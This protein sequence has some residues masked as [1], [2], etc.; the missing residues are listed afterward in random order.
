[1]VYVDSHVTDKIVST[2]QNNKQPMK[3]RR[4]IVPFIMGLM[5][6]VLF[7]LQGTSSD[8]LV[9][10]QD[11]PI[12]WI[13]LTTVYVLLLLL[14]SATR[15]GIFSVFP[16]FPVTLAY[17]LLPDI[18]TLMMFLVGNGIIALYQIWWH[19]PFSKNISHQNTRLMPLYH[20]A[21]GI[22]QIISSGYAILIGRFLSQQAMLYTPTDAETLQVSGVI[23]F[24]MWGIMV[25][26]YQ[27][28]KVLLLGDLKRWW[29]YSQRYS[30]RDTLLG[31]SALVTVT[32]YFAIGWWGFLV[33]TGLVMGQAIRITQTRF[34]RQALLQR[35]SEIS[36]MTNLARSGKDGLELN[37]VM[38]SI[39]TEIAKALPMDA[40]FIALDDE[41]N[42]DFNYAYSVIQHRELEHWQAPNGIHHLVQITMQQRAYT[43]CHE[44]HD[45]IHALRTADDHDYQS[46]LIM[47]LQVGI[48]L[49]GAIGVMHRQPHQYDSRYVVKLQNMASQVSLML[50]NASLYQKSKRMTQQLA[51]INSVLQSNLLHL[52]KPKALERACQVA[53]DIAGSQRAI[54]FLAQA[55]HD[56]T[57][58]DN[59]TFVATATFSANGEPL[60]E[61]DTLTMTIQANRHADGNYIVNDITTTND[62]LTHALVERIGFQAMVET[63]LHSGHRTLG[64][65]AV[66]HTQA[67]YYSR[68]TI[69]L[70]SMVGNQI[71]TLLE[72]NHMLET[73]E[74]YATEQ[75]QLANL[76]RS[77]NISL[78]LETMLV[79]T[80]L[81]LTT[82][83]Q[84]DHV[85]IGLWD[86][87]ALNIYMVDNEKPYIA[88][89]KPENMLKQESM[90]IVN[91]P[92]LRALGSRQAYEMQVLHRD[93][94]DLARPIKQWLFRQGMAQVMVI[95][96]SINQEAVG[97][98]LALHKQPYTYNDSDLRL[99]EMAVNQVTV[100][101]HNGQLH[102]Q[103]QHALRQG[104]ERLAVIEG[105]TQKISEALN[106]TQ[107][108]QHVLDAAMQSTQADLAYIAIKNDDN[109]YHTLILEKDHNQLYSSQKT[110]WLDDTFIARLM[111]K[112]EVVIVPDVDKML[113]YQAI[114][115][116]V[117]ASILAVPITA[118]EHAIGAL[119]IE[120]RQSRFFSDEHVS[121]VQGI[122]GHASVSLE[123]AH[124][125]AQRQ[126]QINT[127]SALRQL[128]LEA[129]LV[130][131][132][133]TMAHL[134]LTKAV[135]LLGGLCGAIYGYDKP[136]HEVVMIANGSLQKNYLA[137]DDVEV[138]ESA[139]YE[140][141]KTEETQVVYAHQDYLPISTNSVGYET[142]LVIPLHR[143][144]EVTNVIAIG[145]E[146]HW[147]N[148]DSKTLALVTAQAAA[149]LER[150]RLNQAL[151]KQNTQMRAILDANRDGIILLDRVGRLQEANP[152]AEK[153]LNIPLSQHLHEPYEHILMQYV[154]QS[155]DADNRDDVLQ[156]PSDTNSISTRN[157]NLPSEQ[158]LRYIEELSTP[159]TG[160]Q[161]HVVGRLL[162]LRDITEDRQLQEYRQRLQ[163]MLYHDLRSPLGSI[164]SGMYLANTILDDPQG[165]P[166]VESV[167]PTIQI[168]LDSA[169]YLLSMLDTL[170]DIPRLERGQLPLRHEDTTIASL[171][172][173]A[174]T[175]LASSVQT[176]GLNTETQ[177]DD[178][179]PSLYIDKDIIQRVFINL[180]HNAFK[181]TPRDGTIM[182]AAR[183]DKNKEGFVKI[184]ICDTGPGIPAA[185]RERIF[186]EFEQI[187]GHKPHQG[188]K[189]SGLGL[190]F[191]K[192]AVEAHGGRIWVE[193]E[194]LL[195]GAC[196]AFTLPASQ[197]VKQTVHE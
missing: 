36:A 128:T 73:L 173:H 175:T 35:M 171:A 21:S 37:R 60:D 135:Q 86:E 42:Y 55:S 163:S 69:N 105:I 186:N 78:H 66:Y 24:F 40:F 10:S 185:M 146:N 49:I 34:A 89:D 129:T 194:G 103:T 191:C 107:I 162:S 93:D 3:L 98:V 177:F 172:E 127:L 141:I 90:P 25:C 181:F 109:S 79:N 53:C 95:P 54:I 33:V 164:I 192:Q 46:I 6:V 15:E 159:V 114:G 51:T 130:I 176:A 144:G 16:F 11:V 19:R 120:S 140:A 142:M 139:L 87:D 193:A 13:I 45:C 20:E 123:N 115:K 160:N 96:M 97:M 23:W 26:V 62:G 2:A 106:P 70:L 99:M 168:A 41:Q 27:F 68:T 32:A 64:I 118:G 156:L 149:H 57:T 195:S 82:M 74:G 154:S 8:T 110:L 59:N 151:S 104:I 12:L 133:T 116:Q 91:V 63:P 111:D 29:Q 187:E 30:L 47:P 190:A 22:V 169:N 56:D 17:F 166:I 189:G 52:N 138:D 1:M 170:R 102:A 188:G 28:S 184:L 61:V 117:Y 122:A 100:Q 137:V 165:M 38:R 132:E 5:L 183:C 125:L 152:A 143:Q 153:L 131:D 44:Q 4:A 92:A 43:L 39:H 112:Q 84:N 155:D 134:I 119:S 101:I 167:R 197:H 174:F 145:F 81:A 80:C 50:R 31:I 77:V 65:L 178:D 72:N 121:F 85:A 48:K 76:T 113:D 180:I 148:E 179:C 182:V 58:N 124:L 71:A 136:T 7:V 157:Y 147:R 75:A 18:A 126:E 108:S 83:F 161:G 9:T 196:F 158:G 67:H 14:F 94:E 150:A 88:G